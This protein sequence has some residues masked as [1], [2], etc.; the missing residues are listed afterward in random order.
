MKT[1]L[2]GTS[3]AAKVTLSLIVVG[4]VVP[5]RVSL[6]REDQRYQHGMV[7]PGFAA[8]TRR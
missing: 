4:T 8:E 2:R 3:S 6:G 7:G 1:G 5:V